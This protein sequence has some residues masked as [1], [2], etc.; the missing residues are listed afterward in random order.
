MLE[1]TLLCLRFLVA[2]AVVWVSAAMVLST[3]RPHPSL[4]GRH[5]DDPFVRHCPGLRGL[6]VLAVALFGVFALIG[7]CGFFGFTACAGGLALCWIA[8][9]LFVT[10]RR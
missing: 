1:W 3:T 5:W 9:L 4:D 10:G 8:W 2:V 6:A 7:Q